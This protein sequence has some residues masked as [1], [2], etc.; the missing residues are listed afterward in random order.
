MKLLHEN[1]RRFLTES[2]PG[3]EFSPEQIDQWYIEE[4]PEEQEERSPSEEPVSAEQA[5]WGREYAQDYEGVRTREAAQA[6]S[7]PWTSAEQAKGHALSIG[8]AMQEIDDIIAQKQQSRIKTAL[9][10]LFKSIPA[11]GKLGQAQDL[12]GEGDRLK[13]IGNSIAEMTTGKERPSMRMMDII[14]QF[15][16][17]D[18]FDLS[19]KNW[20]APSEM[21]AFR[22]HYR[23]YMA[24]Q[25]DAWGPDAY[26]VPLAAID[27][28]NL[29]F[30]QWKERRYAEEGTRVQESLFEN[31]RKFLAEE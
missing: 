18:K 23:R 19:P 10:K 21:L 9:I 8:E 6:A 20:G 22:E 13:Q 25:V 12:A 5:A 31:W 11:I 24:K 28:I 30:R 1:W 14:Q 2:P 17:L 27:D 29:V 15:P 16:V 4:P 3:S 26:N 7:L